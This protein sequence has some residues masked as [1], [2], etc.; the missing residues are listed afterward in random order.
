MNDRTAVQPRRTQRANS[1]RRGGPAGRQVVGEYVGQPA[2]DAAQAVRRA[3]LCPGLDR[4]F[5]CEAE[6]IGLVVAQEPAAGSDLA[7]NG[8][9][10]LY[11][12]APGAGPMDEEPAATETVDEAPVTVTA[13][14]AEIEPPDAASRPRR[15]R[16][17]KPG[18]ARQATRVFDPPPA[19]IALESEPAEEV[20]LAPEWGSP[21]GE[22]LDEGRL[23]EQSDAELLQDDFVVHLDDVLGGRTEGPPAWR[24]VYPRRRTFAALTSVGG[25][26]VWLS[27]HSL[28]A[29]AVGAALAV[30]I[31]VGLASALGSQ[32]AGTPTASLASPSHRP[33][34]TRTTQAR[35]PVSAPSVA[36]ARPTARSPQ[37]RRAARHSEAPHLDRERAPVIE[38]AAHPERMAVQAPA[39]APPAPPA[40]ASAPAAPPAQQ[41]QGGLFS[42]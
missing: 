30:W 8:M 7:R 10:T 31:L 26:R 22:E 17:R 27:E 20:P 5:G 1:T 36:S 37:V 40:S 41:T 34:R 4:S 18:L 24:R 21:D 13:V 19:P 12:A 3:G 11:V 28:L 9:V 33:A 16:R 32:H 15:A 42:P 25:I 6:L 14:L 39:A 23:E 38:A 2:G 29:K 35:P